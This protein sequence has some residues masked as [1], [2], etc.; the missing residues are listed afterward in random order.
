GEAMLVSQRAVGT[1]LRDKGTDK[2]RGAKDNVIPIAVTDDVS[3]AAAINR[4]AGYLGEPLP[5]DVRGIDQRRSGGVQLRDEG[6]RVD[7]RLR[8]KGLDQGVE[9]VEVVLVGEEAAAEFGNAGHVH[10][11]VAVHGDA[12]PRVFHE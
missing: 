9:A 5:S 10:V 3:I 8:L 1:N 4:D 7:R 6:T 11:A 12:R 2:R